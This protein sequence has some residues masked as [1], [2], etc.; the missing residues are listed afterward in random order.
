MAMNIYF[1][2]FDFMKDFDSR[3]GGDLYMTA[4]KNFVVYSVVIDN[5]ESIDNTTKKNSGRYKKY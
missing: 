3:R 4:N 1:R 2:F 5:I